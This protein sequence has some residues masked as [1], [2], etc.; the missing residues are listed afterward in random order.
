MPW[1]C[2]PP[3]AAR[4]RGHFKSGL[5]HGG[6]P[7]P[8]GIGSLKIVEPRSRHVL[9]A[10]KST[11]VKPP[12]QAEGHEVI[13]AKNRVGQGG[14]IEGSAPRRMG[15]VDVRS[16]LDDQF[17]QCRQAGLLLDTLIAKLAVCDRSGMEPRPENLPKPASS[18][19][20][21]SSERG[22]KRKVLEQ[23]RGAAC[24]AI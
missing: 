24:V 1:Q 10:A 9:R 21:M 13:R 11:L 7:R 18:A 22:A 14:E 15:S 6:Y 17:W 3:R 20:H 23:V 5:G 16:A 12:H 8:K 2:A 19:P 4:L